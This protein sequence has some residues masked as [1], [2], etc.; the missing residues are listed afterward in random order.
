MTL[1]NIVF[2]TLYYSSQVSI[3]NLLQSIELQKRVKAF[4]LALDTINKCL[5]EAICSV[6]RGRS[7]GESRTAGLIHSGN[8][9]IEAF[10]YD[11][12]V[13]SQEREL[14]LEQQ[15]VLRQLEAILAIHKLAGQGN[16]VDTLRE[17]VKLTFLPLD[18]RAPDVTRDTFQNL[19]PHVQ[20]CVPDLLKVALNCLDSVP[21]TDGSL[22]AIR[23][24]IANF[25]ANNMNRN[26]PRDLYDKVARNL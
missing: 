19:S 15:T 25:L 17:I 16:Y 20:A 24:K 3:I 7:D 6:S 10:K 2:L 5:S 11:T 4:S 18:P 26:W 22:R 21:D 13:G 14:V 23:A 12:Q 9:I 1:S 8:E